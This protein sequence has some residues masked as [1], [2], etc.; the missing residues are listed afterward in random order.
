MAAPVVLG[1]D[2]GGSKMAAAVTDSAGTW[3][4]RA[5]TDVQP[6]ATADETFTRGI[7]A[8][9]RL[10]EQ[11]APRSPI[12]AV[13]ACTFGIPYDDRVDLA[14]NVV[15]WGELAFG[16][17]LRHAFPGTPVAVATDVKAAARAEL[18]DGALAGCDIG[19]YVNLG[20][21]LAVAIVVDGQVVTGHHAAA[22]EIGYNL[23][24]VRS[25]K[26]QDRLEDVVS[27][28]ALEAAAEHILGRP[29]V[30]A[31][32]AGSL[33]DPAAAA[34]RD[35]FRDELCF[36][37]VNLVIALDPQR[38]VVGG[39]LVRSWAV[40]GPSIAAALDTAVPFPPEL[41]VAAHPYDAP[42][43]GALALGRSL[44]PDLSTVADVFSEGASA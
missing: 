14:P 16:A 18:A 33:S 41:V 1:L 30:P 39:G 3:L 2:F 19:L 6:S 31:L 17:R 11:T 27:G 29:D 40:L 32:L 25:L 26:T 5:V 36:H 42:L 15:G 8:A 12:A 38:V 4:G 7:G 24:T 43:F 20:T 21:G 9:R 35:E 28:K 23:R 37:L 44:V 22:G 10:V 13:G 34:A